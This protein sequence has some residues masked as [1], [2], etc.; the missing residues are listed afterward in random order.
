MTHQTDMLEAALPSQAQLRA[1][2]RRGAAAQAWAQ[3]V[4]K[5]DRL[6][7][8]TQQKLT[9]LW[10]PIRQLSE[11]HRGRVLQ[12]LLALNSDDR[13]LRFGQ[14]ASDEQIS[15]YVAAMNFERD[16][17]FGIFGRSLRIV[18][19]AHLALA[20]EL[21]EGELGVSV[22][23]QARGRGLGGHLFD[24]ATVQAR[25]RGARTMVIH[26]A[27]HN[28]AMLAIV[29]RAGAKVVFSGPD[30]IA[31]LPLNCATWATQVGAALDQ[32]AAEVDFQLKLQV[33]RLD[34]WL[35]AA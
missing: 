21:H 33:H 23:P 8:N 1:S 30:A 27:R 2:A 22:L 5:L 26:L 12:H 3:T 11:R 13:L 6:G 32:Q 28:T 31:T 17:I 16:E 34:R 35:P 9:R 19:M 25:N 20:D 14:L 24:R 29:K 7:H 10:V 4:G 15:R 18:A